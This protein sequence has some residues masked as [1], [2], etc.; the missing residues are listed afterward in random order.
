VRY[1]RSEVVA[2]QN[3]PHPN[4]A[5]AGILEQARCQ[6]G[7]LGAHSRVWDSVRVWENFGEAAQQ[8]GHQGCPA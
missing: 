6:E 3:S 8:T 7:N 1:P 2:L 5:V 4:E